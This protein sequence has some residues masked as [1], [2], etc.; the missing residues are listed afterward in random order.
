MENTRSE[1]IIIFNA[2]TPEITDINVVNDCLKEFFSDKKAI[3]H[4]DRFNVIAFTKSGP[5]YLEDF[6]LN[7]EYVSEVLDQLEPEMVRANISGGIFIAATFTAEVFKKI[8]GKV[9]RLII[10]SDSGSLKIKEDHLFFI[11]DLLDKVKNIPFIVD[12]V[13]IDTAEQPRED[14]V[15]MRLAKKTGGDFYEIKNLISKKRQPLLNKKE[16]SPQEDNIISKLSDKTKRVASFLMGEVVEKKGE[17]E[18]KKEEP[19]DLPSVLEKLAKKKEL[20]IGLLDEDDRMDIPEQNMIFFESL[21]DQPKPVEGQ[22][23]EK[24]TICFTYVSKNQEKLECPHCD[25]LYHKICLAIWAKNSY[26]SDAAPHLFRCPNCY[27]LLRLDKQFIELVQKTKTPVIEMLDLED[28]LLE[29]YL[30]SLESEEGPSL[31]STEDTF[32]PSEPEESEKV[33]GELL[34]ETPEEVPVDELKMIW[35]PNCNAMIT[36]EFPECTR[37]GRKLTLEDRQLSRAT[38]STETPAESEILRTN[39]ITAEINKLRVQAKTDMKS[40]DY[41][42]ALNK[43]EKILELSKEIE[44]EDIQK[45]Q[46]VFI[47]NAKTLAKQKIEIADIKRKV[48]FLQDKYDTLMGENRDQEAKRLVK[49][50]M[51]RYQQTLDQITVP[52]V[53]RFLGRVS[54]EKEQ[55]ISEEKTPE[56]PIIV[57]PVAST[58]EQIDTV[59][60]IAEE[61]MRKD[62]IFEDEKDELT[63][64]KNQI[65]KI[66]IALE[67]SNALVKQRAYEEA[68]SLLDTTAQEIRA[69]ELTDYKERIATKKAEIQKAKDDYLEKLEKIKE[70]EKK[71]EDLRRQKA[72][73]SAKKIALEL[74]E[75]AKKYNLVDDKKKY[76]QTIEE[77]DREIEKA[78]EKKQQKLQSLYRS[79]KELE[80]LIPAEEEVLNQQEILKGQDINSMLS[81]EVETMVELIS[82]ILEEQRNKLE[83]EIRYKILIQQG[84][85]EYLK[86]DEKVPINIRK[87]TKKIAEDTFHEQILYENNLTFSTPLEENIANYTLTVTVPYHFQ[88][89]DCECKLKDS[90]LLPEKTLLEK[91]LELKW[92]LKDLSA[93][94]K[95]SIQIDYNRRV[96]RHIILTDGEQIRI[97]RAY[98]DIAS[99]QDKEYNNIQL[100]IHIPQGIQAKWLVLEDIIPP[101]YVPLIQRPSSLESLDCSTSP[102]G[103]LL[104][105]IFANVT[106]TFL[107]FDYSLLTSEQIQILNRHLEANQEI[108]LQNW[109]EVNPSTLTTKAKE[110]WDALR[111]LF[112]QEPV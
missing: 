10:L 61:P 18:E 49:D 43:A 68:I 69:K 58:E 73:K 110:L 46:L 82:S 57:A 44:D 108:L 41:T 22:E 94:E 24:C 15:L 63:A 106:D 23:K 91:G 88:V 12:V 66:D 8:S 77:L 78:E 35:C 47:E 26:I 84:N 14:L 6:T 93:Q 4:N 1:D 81:D 20:P 83:E 13:R 112:A 30:Q 105:W 67:K 103:K 60:A 98:Y 85:N 55:A 70:L 76:I 39:E 34:A 28:L 97:I 80:K 27:T 74:S 40:E 45:E 90:T 21:A 62:N 101:P 99:S 102:I 95:V 53:E 31:V 52:A 25:S 75:Q 86:K 38:S 89:S 111:D 79:A 65:D 100:S 3:D 50:F 32:S 92:E 11:E 17:K 96:C 109:N 54:H 36:N 56:K 5:K 16:E 33:K 64:L 42:E 87:I 37:C 72:W 104:G 107:K 19:K 7:S 71:L 48:L 29:E 51:E 2:L 59:E 9:F